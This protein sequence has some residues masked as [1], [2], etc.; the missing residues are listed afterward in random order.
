[1]RIRPFTISDEKLKRFYPQY[2]TEISA[3]NKNSESED[4]SSVEGE[5]LP[6]Y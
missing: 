6:F 5:N 2:F 4:E 1:M 3:E